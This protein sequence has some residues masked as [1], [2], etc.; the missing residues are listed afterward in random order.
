MVGHG[1]E[2]ARDAAVGLGELGLAEAAGD[3][4]L[5]FA[6]P[7]VALGAAVREG[8]VG[9]SG[10]QQHGAFMFL[11]S[12]TEVVGIGFRD[13]TPLAVL[14]CRDG[15]QLPLPPRVRMLR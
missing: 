4:L 8:N 12:L 6:H 7:Q 5:H 2:V 15:W 1:L 9:V 11:Q 10:E 13:S 14:L 3:F